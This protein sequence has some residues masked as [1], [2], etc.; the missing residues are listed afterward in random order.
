MVPVKSFANAKLRLAPALSPDERRVLA[1][2]LADG[3]LAAAG[4]L[5]SYVVCDDEEVS[6]WA[7]AAGAEVIYTPGLGLSGAV[8]AAVAELAKRRFETV[9]VAHADLAHPGGLS[10]VAID[11]AVVLVPDLRHDGTNVVSV[12]AGAGFRFA[13]GAGSFERH[14]S[15]AT[16]LRL[17]CLVVHDRRLAADIDVPDDLRFLHA[18]PIGDSPVRVTRLGERLGS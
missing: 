10:S 4:E 2:Q 3:V 7:K 5:P 15:E 16:R 14:R 18:G 11:D 8:G 12:P 1:R 6:A 9:L 17:P 13:Y